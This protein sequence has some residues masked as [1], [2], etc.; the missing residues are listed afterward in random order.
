M[1]VGPAESCL[2]EYAILL[3]K[4]PSVAHFSSAR[5]WPPPALH[6][7]PPR[8]SVEPPRSRGHRSRPPTTT[9]GGHRV[10]YRLS[11]SRSN[12]SAQGRAS[13]RWLVRISVAA[14]RLLTSSLWSGPASR[15]PAAGMW[16]QAAAPSVCM[17]LRL[18]PLGG[19]AAM[20]PELVA[21]P[22]LVPFPLLPFDSRASPGAGASRLPAVRITSRRCSEITA[23]IMV[24]HLLRSRF[25]CRTSCTSAFRAVASCA[26][27]P[28]S[29][30]ATSLRMGRDLMNT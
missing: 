6:P 26:L 14:D 27:R 18:W 24:E 5:G 29:Q 12:G 13:A 7:E 30:S 23:V 2:P 8:G 9:H 22:R 3:V 4:R 11:P 10:R 25:R 21:S 19:T 28:L 15:G 17:A 20:M 16:A 1:S